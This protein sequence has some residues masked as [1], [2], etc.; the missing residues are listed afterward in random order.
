[1]LHGHGCLY[2]HR[3]HLALDVPLGPGS[4]SAWAYGINAAGTIVGRYYDAGFKTHGFLY[5]NGTY[6]ILDDPL[7]INGNA[8]LGINDSGQIV[9][10][11]QNQN[12]TL[13][14]G[15]LKVTMPNPPPPAGTTA[16]MI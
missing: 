9:G 8:A 2:D 4:F 13:T 14:H 11:Y 15:F 12:G 3:T 16:A 1:G 7:G 6:T 5:S 10:Q